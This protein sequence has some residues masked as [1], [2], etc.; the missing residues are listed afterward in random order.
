MKTKLVC[1]AL[2]LFPALTIAGHPI[3]PIV[4]AVH[5]WPGY[6]GRDIRCVPLLPF[7][8]PLPVPVVY[9][10]PAVA[11][12]LALQD[13]RAVIVRPEQPVRITITV[14]MSPRQARELVGAVASSG[15]LE[16]LRK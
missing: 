7:A 3:S 13:P 12:I 15:V 6:A 2:F 9:R 8:T 11:P 14:E 10:V 4:R 1:V 16:K 5:A